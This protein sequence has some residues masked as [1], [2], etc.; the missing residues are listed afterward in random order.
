MCLWRRNRL[1]YHTF[2]KRRSFKGGQTQV[3]NLHRAGGPSDEDVVTLEVTCQLWHHVCDLIDSVE[4]V[5]FQMAGLKYVLP[6]K[7]EI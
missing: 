2:G 5:K 4:T 6:R 7:I 1:T 3:T